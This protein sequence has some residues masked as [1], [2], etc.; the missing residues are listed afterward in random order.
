MERKHKN[1]A[2][3][4]MT[5]CILLVLLC[6]F[7]TSLSCQAQ[8]DDFGIWTSIEVQKKINKKWNVAAEA[9]MRTRDD[10]GTVDRWS[11]GLDVDYKIVKG[12]KLSAGYTYLYDN[13]LR[14]TFHSDG[15]LNKEAK[16]WGSRHRFLVSLTGE[17][18]FGNFGLS[19][20]ERWQYTYRPEQSVAERYD[21][22]DE[23]WDGEA[24]SWR[25][26]GKN[27]LRSRLQAEYKLKPLKLTPY[28]SV[29]MYNA[30]SVQKMRYTLG[31]DW[32]ITKQHALSVYYRYQNVRQ[33]DD[34]DNE[35]DRH[36]LGVGYKF[37]F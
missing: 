22:D 30:W 17:K 1:G 28:A 6:C 2:K 12:L 24:K 27:V 14:Q 13:N 20:R 35:P 34:F 19:L 15:S 5:R 37:K 9:E 26:K 36:I 3:R 11:G 21:Y 29:E 23:D 8:G 7:V 10:V 31:T 25:G 16:Y 4:Q 32:K 33:S 18:S